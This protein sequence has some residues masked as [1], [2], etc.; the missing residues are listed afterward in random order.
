M[1]GIFKKKTQLEQGIAK[2]GLD[3]AAQRIAE[4]TCRKKI[5]NRGVARQFVLEDLHGAS[6]GNKSS[7][8]W[9]A[10]SGYPADMYLGSLNH[11]SPEV[12]GPD[13]PQMFLNMMSLEISDEPLRAE[14]RMQVTEHIM[15]H[16]QLGKYTQENDFVNELLLELKNVIEDDNS[17]L[18]ALA[19]SMPEIPGA[20]LRHIVNRRKNLDK[21]NEIIDLIKGKTKES[22]DL[23]LKKALSS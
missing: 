21:A 23:I 8:Q 14:F 2:D 10:N 20:P 11:S 4:I 1:F 16:F 3:H 19:P 13:G 12:D 5:P 6:M 15:R 18:P 7:Q 9:A 17:V 22:T